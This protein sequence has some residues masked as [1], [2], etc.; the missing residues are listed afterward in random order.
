[1]TRQLVMAVG[2]VLAL[3]GLGL[4]QT[5]RGAGAAGQGTE[6]AAGPLVRTA[7]VSG[8]VVDADSGQPI[9]GALVRMQSRQ[10]AAAATAEGRGRGRGM[11]AVPLPGMPNGEPPGSALVVTDSDGTFRFVALPAG[12]TQ[13]T[14]SA[15]GY[16][17]PRTPNRA[18]QL[19]DA[20]QRTGVLLKLSKAASISGI[21]T[22][23]AGEPVVGIPVRALRRQTPS[24]VPV[25]AFDGPIGRTDDRGMYRI[26]GIRPGEVY[27]VVPQTQTVVPASDL[28]KVN[29][30]LQLV[31]PLMEALTGGARGPATMP[32]SVRVGDRAVRVGGAAGDL[33]TPAPPAN[34]RLAAYPP[35]LYPSATSLAQATP[36][37]LASG[38]Q[39]SGADIQVRPVP[40]ISIDGTLLGAAGP[41]AGAIV[42]LVPAPGTA[43]EEPLAVARA[44]TDAQGRF[45]FPSVPSGS[46]VAKAEVSTGGG[47]PPAMLSEALAQMPPEM[48]AQLQARMNGQA[49]STAYLSA[50]IEAADRD[51]T[52]LS[53]TLRHGAK[54]RGTL[55]FDGAAA[56]PTLTNAQVQFTQV[57][58][59]I[60][61]SGKVQS[62][63][64]FESS[65]LP[66]GTFRVTINGVPG[67]WLLT[68]VSS[69]GRD[70]RSQTVQ[71]GADGAPNV[72]LRFTDR[73]A[74]I[75]GG[76]RGDSG[77]SLPNT[78]V[79]LIGAD[80]ADAL[81]RGLP[82]TT[83][84][85]P[86]QQNALFTLNRLR[87]GDY[88][89]VAIP[90]DAVP[91]DYDAAFYA[92]VA[93]LGT[94]VTVG[95]GEQ[96]AQDLVLVQA[97]VR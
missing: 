21:V 71:T 96:R 87:A 10:L 29:P 6:A 50:P 83:M 4:A 46:Y 11:N 86:V 57:G 16:L 23:E 13:L 88:F 75:R 79:V 3:P 58:G 38:D 18:V 48:A 61:A 67:P 52:G 25:W 69:G 39:K 32:A 35:T 42:R 31:S 89:I 49:R 94:R 82:P 34:G 56:P 54:A 30:G 2:L 78:S 53:L 28:E 37:T 8:R 65:D 59:T 51:V 20:E 84:V 62:D 33:M 68:S 7:S 92:A 27:V 91:P 60:S 26:D 12:A 19:E 63:L 93:R 1:M 5:G 24:G 74:S 9:A 85:V 64:T 70:A 36:F 77:A 97:R 76:V 44:T 90:D 17:A 43:S 15:A 66:E 72:T 81:D 22:D 45:V 40:S 73:V 95:E 14:P 47:A 80:Y 55:V 41:A